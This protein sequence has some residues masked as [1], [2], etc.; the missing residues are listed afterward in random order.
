[1]YKL[2][3]FCRDT[4]QISH[5]PEHIRAFSGRSTIGK[6][7]GSVTG[8]ERFYCPPL[9]AGELS[10]TVDINA[11]SHGVLISD[12]ALIGHGIPAQIQLQ[13]EQWHPSYI[14]RKGT[15]HTYLGPELLSLSIE[16]WVVPSDPYVGP[17]V[18]HGRNCLYPPNV[19]LHQLFS[20]GICP[21]THSIY[22]YS[23][24]IE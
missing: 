15:V 17:H 13:S 11:V 7:D 14:W 22:K 10:F 5:I 1:M 18:E 16:T 3:D 20:C 8:V 12:Q 21:K 23:F 9:A 2:N 19:W 4:Q 6:M 24:C